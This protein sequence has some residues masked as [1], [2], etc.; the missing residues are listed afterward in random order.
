MQHSGEAGVDAI[1]PLLGGR[2]CAKLL[3]FPVIIAFPCIKGTD[4]VIL[5]IV[6]CTCYVLIN[7]VHD[8]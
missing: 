2:T 1:L 7:I 4:I 6:L 3:F 5:I 8:T